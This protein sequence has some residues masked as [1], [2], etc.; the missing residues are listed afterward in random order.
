MV[1]Q[2]FAVLFIV[3][4]SSTI[5]NIFRFG[6]SETLYVISEIIVNVANLF[7]FF[8]LV[9]KAF[10][11]PELFVGVKT[12]M[13]LAR[14]LEKI[15]DDT[16]SPEIIQKVENHMKTNEPFIDASLSVYDLAKQIDVSARELSV[17]INN[18]LDK[19][20]FDY[21]N[22]YRIEKAM[23]ILKQTTDEKLTVLEVLY[24]VGFNSKSF[25]NTAFKKFAGTTPS[26]FK[27]KASGSAA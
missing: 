6:D 20:F 8:W 16:H 24:E 21:V 3:D 2:F 4:F 19:H 18:H 23:E 1:I 15:E 10:K 14:K 11:K 7:V 17:A 13:Q 12:D 26:E 9:I 22:E 27:R 5:K 25:F